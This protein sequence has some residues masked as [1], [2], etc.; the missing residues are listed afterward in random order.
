MSSNPGNPVLSDVIEPQLNPVKNDIAYIDG[1]AQKYDGTQWNKLRQ[2]DIALM[3]M[4][5]FNNLSSMTIMKHIV[6]VKEDVQVLKDIMRTLQATRI[7]ADNALVSLGTKLDTD[8]GVTSTD[9]ES[10]VLANLN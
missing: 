6:E 8:A 2:Y 10:T 7:K 1:E 9:Y 3:A 5:N 4:E